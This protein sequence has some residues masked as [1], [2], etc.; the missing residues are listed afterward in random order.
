MEH[1]EKQTLLDLRKAETALAKFAASPIANPKTKYKL[2]KAFKAWNAELMIFAEQ[3]DALMDKHC[4]AIFDENGEKTGRYKP[5]K[6]YTDALGDLLGAEI[7]PPLPTVAI[8]V[9]EI[10]E[11]VT[12]ADIANAGNFIVILEDGE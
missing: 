2:A 5:S 4:E 9:S 1:S 6:A 8:P 3:Q 7:L 12:A 11:D 10:P